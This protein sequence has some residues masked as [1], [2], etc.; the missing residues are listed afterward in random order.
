MKFSNDKIHIGID[1]GTSF[2]TIA[3]Y[4]PSLYQPQAIELERETF[5]IPSFVTFKLNEKDST[6]GSYSVG[7]N[8]K[9]DHSSNPTLYNAKRFI[10]KN[11][12]EIE[13]MKEER[14]FLGFDIL[15][16]DDL[17]KMCSPSVF[18]PSKLDGFY[19]EEIIAL[20][21]RTMLR[22]IYRICQKEDIGR[23][24]VSVPNSFSIHQREAIIRAGQ[25]SNLPHV[26]LIN[27]TSAAIIE[28]VR[29]FGSTM[30]PNSKVLVIDCGGSYLNLSYCIVNGSKIE[31]KS[32]STDEF[33]GGFT[34]DRI[35]MK[36]ILDK[37]KELEI[38]EEERQ[39]FIINENDPLQLKLEK[40]KKIRKFHCICE[41]YKRT[42]T[43]CHEIEIKIS[44]ILDGYDNLSF[45]LTLEEF[46]NAC[47][48]KQLVKQMIGDITTLL[49]T[50]NVTLEDIDF[51]LPIGGSMMMPFTQKVLKI[52]IPD[53]SKY[54]QQEF[55]RTTLV[56]KGA[57]YHSYQRET[58]GDSYNFVFTDILSYSVGI[59]V[60]E[61]KLM[62]R[63]A[64]KGSRIPLSG[65]VIYSQTIE[66]QN[67]T[68]VTYQLYSGESSVTTDKDM[69]EIQKFTIKLINQKS[70]KNTKT[71]LEVHF[72]IDRNG[73][74]YIKAYQQIQGKNPQKLP[75][76]MECSKDN[77]L[78]DCIKAHL[79]LF[80]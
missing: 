13:M 62:D 50:G 2:S 24:T 57:A 58:M 37:M 73:L 71:V 1:F 36:L 20:I 56:C 70:S 77:Y 46:E 65:S 63:F 47:V 38:K 3:T 4:D 26:S 53:E 74:V 33:F 28:Y 61:Q 49:Q 16:D 6:M 25:L 48:S 30:K 18:N 12:Q 42:L 17:V 64:S 14:K 11:Y 35:M 51:V 32:S 76:E 59:S 43:Y 31:I 9:E 27:E 40:Q 29:L 23:I 54:P 39:M 45:T 69:K 41:E 60:G 66:N 44:S 78:L 10:G 55:D 8:S 67:Q 80:E 19:P 21:L 22:Q 52:L 7:F 75:V 68:E 34:F 5:E 72:L 15:E 79:L